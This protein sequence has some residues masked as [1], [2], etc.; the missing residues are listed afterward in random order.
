MFL[1]GITPMAVL[2][3]AAGV[4]AGA[5][6]GAA[7]AFLP[8]DLRERAMLGDAGANAL[9]AFLGASVFVAS[10]PSWA[11]LLVLGVVLAL[12]A[13]ADRPGFGA[14]IARTP[15]LRTFDRAWRVEEEEPALT[16]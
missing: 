3:G 8:E 1:L 13:I 14:V 9:G 4:V 16:P 15:G 5:A 7:V 6:L 10:P 11:R 12:T 2:S